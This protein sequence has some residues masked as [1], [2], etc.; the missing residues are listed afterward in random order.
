[1]KLPDFILI[2]AMKSGTTSLRKSLHLH[3]DIFM[4]YPEEPRFFYNDI[5][6]E[7]GI[8]WYSNWFKE[9]KTN[10]ICGEG[11]G[12]YSH[13]EKFPYTA[14]RIHEHLPNCKI[15]YLV[16][17]PIDRIKSHWSWEVANGKTVGNL[18]EAIVNKP[19]YIEQSNY[20]NQLQ[21]FRKFYPDH[22]IQILFFE[23]LKKDETS[24][25]NTLWDFLEV[26]KPLTNDN[27][28]LHENKT[29]GRLT[30]TNLLIKLRTKLP[31]SFTRYIPENLKTLL[32][33]VLKTNEPPLPKFSRE[34]IHFL[35]SKLT[36]DS[37]KFLDYAKKSPEFWGDLFLNN[38]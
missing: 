32:I 16:R 14:S 36:D 34:S 9:A 29:Q 15:L 11:S 5:N 26:K 27:E 24:F 38:N 17:H 12:F 25:L 4:V 33:K 2:G 1:M 6:Y 21:E 20:W 3:K 28:L 37:K 10:Q 31:P 13:K 30:D 22:K 7:K 8:G 19:Y 35:K 23:D 18:N